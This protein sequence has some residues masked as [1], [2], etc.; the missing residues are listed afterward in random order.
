MNKN[1]QLL[2]R[3]SKLQICPRLQTQNIMFKRNSSLTKI[4]T[5]SEHY[6]G[7]FLFNEN[8]IKKIKPIIILPTIHFFLPEFRCSLFQP[9]KRSNKNFNGMLL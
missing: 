3:D 8:E 7:L 6:T 1:N 4:E 9:K 5:I 2:Q